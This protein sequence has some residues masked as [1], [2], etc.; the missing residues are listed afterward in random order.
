MKIVFTPISIVIGLLAGMA[1]KKIFE[2][3]WGLI[4]EEEPPRPEHREFSW[5]K[6][7]AALVVE[8]AVF[9]LV[10]G[11]VDHGTRT[12]FARATGA[13]PGEERPERE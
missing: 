8:G 6:L 9:R 11:L 5:P 12:T 4:D 10:K 2:Q 3:V 1:G 7:I 13:W